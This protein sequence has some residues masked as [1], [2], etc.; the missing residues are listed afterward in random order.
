MSGF[1]VT[2]PLPPSAN[3]LFKNIAHGRA[4]TRAYVEWRHA[5]EAQLRALQLTPVR[6]PYELAILVP[7]GAG[8]IS[9]RI[10]AV[11]DI[12]VKVGLTDDDKHN[13]AVSARRYLRVPPGL[14]TVIVRSSSAAPAGA[15]GG[16]APLPVS[17]LPEGA[18]ADLIA[19]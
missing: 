17:S 14:C 18:K 10:K 13:E 12:L 6:G 5:A 4:K 11:E 3:K 9:N 16:P 2:L 7:R 1:E 8:D 19:A 15:G